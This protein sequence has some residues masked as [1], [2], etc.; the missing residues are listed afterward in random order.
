MRGF[1]VQDCDDKKN[2][3]QKYYRWWNDSVCCKGQST[4]IFRGCNKSKRRISIIFFM[5]VFVIIASS[6]L[7]VSFSLFYSSS[8][9]KSS[10][11]L[12]QNPLPYLKTSPSSLEGV[13]VAE[14]KFKL[15]MEER[16]EDMRK[17]HEIWEK[18]IEQQIE[19]NHHD[20]NI[21][22]SVLLSRASNLLGTFSEKEESLQVL[23]DFQA[24]LDH[25]ETTMKDVVRIMY[26]LHENH[27]DDAFSELMR[28]E[29]LG[30]EDCASK[31]YED[32]RGRDKI[33]VFG[34]GMYRF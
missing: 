8:K 2:K 30:L 5:I 17:D 23:E 6:C 4:A 29:M 22:M 15:E 10:T 3:K 33:V 7:I 14:N 32:R 1:F 19:R 9:I 16:F 27:D 34:L 13:V 21:N 31:H 26:P 20:D 24:N 12:R 25:L 11:A 28:K 18:K